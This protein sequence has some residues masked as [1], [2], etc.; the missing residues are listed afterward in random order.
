MVAK[1]GRD[2]GSSTGKVLGSDLKVMSTFLFVFFVY[3]GERNSL[4]T[5]AT[6]C[7]IYSLKRF[8]PYFLQVSLTSSVL[9]S[10]LQLPSG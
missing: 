7:G 8:L 9:L 4:I 5:N 2:S 6:V 10:T 3:I 1:C